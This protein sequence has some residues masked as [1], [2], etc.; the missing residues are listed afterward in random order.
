MSA[1][2]ILTLGL[3]I[4]SARNCIHSAQSLL[5]DN[6]DTLADEE[7]AHA[8]R[9]AH[10]R[11]AVCAGAQR[12]AAAAALEAQ[13]TLPVPGSSTSCGQAFRQGAQV[14]NHS[15]AQ[16][17]K[18][19]RAFRYAQSMFFL[20]AQPTFD[21]SGTQRTEGLQPIPMGEGTGARAEH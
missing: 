3:G 20:E 8:T 5:A 1:L 7:D 19:T 6:Q 10:R 13:A 15:R 17:A 14:H 18:R 9:A 11:T 12:A 4:H 16:Q 2:S 21:P